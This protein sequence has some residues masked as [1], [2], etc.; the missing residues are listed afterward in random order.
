MKSNKIAELAAKFQAK[1]IN[2][3]APPPPPPATNDV[4]KKTQK[5]NANQDEKTHKLVND[6][7]QSYKENDKEKSKQIEHAI[8]KNLTKIV[9]EE[10]FFKLLSSEDIFR[11]LDES[12]ILD[13]LLNNKEII[14]SFIQKFCNNK[15]EAGPILITK[16]DP[17]Y[18]NGG[19]LKDMIDL[20]GAFPYPILRQI[21]EGYYNEQTLLEPDKGYEIEQKD[22]II[23]N[24]NEKI[25]ELQKEIEKLKKKALTPTGPYLS[26]LHEA[27]IK[28]QDSSAHD[29]LTTN[30]EYLTQKDLK[31]RTP[32]FVACEVGNYN[33][34]QQMIEKGVNIEEPNDDRNTPL[35]TA[36]YK[37]HTKIVNYLLD[38][39]ANIS[40]KNKDGDT[41]LHLAAMFARLDV[42]KALLD[43]R[44]NKKAVN[45]SGLKPY[46]VACYF[47]G[48]YHRTEMLKL[49]R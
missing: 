31:G 29:L 42:V 40:A 12:H 11:I 13:D 43:R 44:A 16:L 6:L 20:I 24:L 1:P 22:E 14:I 32:F 18:G 23:K 25:E 28:S 45:N 38:N 7:L 37:G 48:N 46:D 8:S 41:A 33:L 15:P 21:H 5:V 17:S 4:T 49:L 10:D 36:A 26:P 30:P 39:K 35:I 2:P 19:T 9:Y 3:I 47:A 27:L 34:V